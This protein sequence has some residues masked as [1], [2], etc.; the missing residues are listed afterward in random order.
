[1]VM[2]MGMRERLE[3]RAERR[4]EWA[5]KAERRGEAHRTASD[6]LVEHIP[7]G[8]P[9]LVGH[10]SEGRHRRTMTRA[11]NHMFAMVA[12]NKL[13]ERHESKADGIE[14]QLERSIFSDD[15]DATEKV[16]ERIA[17]NEAKRDHMKKVNVLYRKAD[18]EGLKALGLDYDTLKVGVD[19]GYSWER[20]P[21]VAYE[22]TNL[23]A[24]IRDDKKRLGHIAVLS[25]RRAKAEASEAGVT[26]EKSSDGSYCSVTFAE[27]PAR[28]VLNDLRAAG[29]HWSAASW[30]GYTEKIP[31]S[32]NE[33]LS[34][35][36][37]D[38]NGCTTD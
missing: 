37:S 12:E 20:A 11:Q 30:H 7:F 10:H 23:G 14:N 6:R 28:S 15:S 13:A 35:E 19:A 27:K 8:Q 36:G 22:L 1:M 17:A 32:V 4:R 26:I 25:D 9:I 21:Y 38:K 33:M 24:R 31:A 16:K 3:A 34:P 29:F 18:R 2:M 5:V